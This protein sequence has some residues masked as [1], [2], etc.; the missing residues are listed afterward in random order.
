MTGPGFNLAVIV[1]VG[2]VR[3][4]LYDALKCATDLNAKYFKLL[5]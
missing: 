1:R 2:G 5:S 4:I 3:G